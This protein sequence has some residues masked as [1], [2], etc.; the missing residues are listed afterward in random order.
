MVI[1]EGNG[2]GKVGCSSGLSDKVASGA[3]VV[4]AS[5]PLNMGAN[6]VA[7]AAPKVHSSAKF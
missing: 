5:V 4:M 7:V 2:E 3:R 1:S 6:I